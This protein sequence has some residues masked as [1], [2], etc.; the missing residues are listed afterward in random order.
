MENIA[1]AWEPFEIQ[2]TIDGEVKPLLVIPD[3]DEPKYAIFDQY[4]SLGT[5][6][7]ESGKTGKVWC[8]EGMAVKALLTQLGEQLEDYFNN[9]P[10]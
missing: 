3:R 10:V 1:D 2:V 9:K 4:T 5:V 7:Q 8:G 6:W